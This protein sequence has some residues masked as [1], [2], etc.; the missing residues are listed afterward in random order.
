MNSPVVFL[1]IDGVLNSAEDYEMLHINHLS[2]LKFYSKGDFVSKIK[3]KR[4]Q[5]FLNDIDAKVVFVSSWF[6]GSP[7]TEE[8]IRENKDM[9]RFLGLESRALGVLKYTG[10]GLGRG[11]EVLKMVETLELV[12]WIV[13]DDAGSNMYDFEIHKIYGKIGITDTDIKTLKERLKNGKH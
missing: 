7:N 13:V 11:K 9:I 5:K 6:W 1:D 4:L 12:N 2:N 10:G 8:R 3:L